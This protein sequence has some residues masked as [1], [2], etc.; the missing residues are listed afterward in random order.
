MD[1]KIFCLWS[2]FIFI[3]FSQNC[4]SKKTQISSQTDFL[5]FCSL[6]DAWEEISL[7]TK[8]KI[9]KNEILFLF[10]LKTKGK[11]WLK[12]TLS[13]WKEK[14]E[15]HEDNFLQMGVNETYKTLLLN[16]CV[17]KLKN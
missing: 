11:S 15:I 7:N 2:G 1:G 10:V 6:G 13:Y 16:V 5:A 12:F 3:L 9:V 4:N 8:E 14:G 17:E